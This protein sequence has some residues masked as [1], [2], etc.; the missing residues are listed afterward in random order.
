MVFALLS[1]ISNGL[2]YV[3]ASLKSILHRVHCIH[4]VHLML[5][6]LSSSTLFVALTLVV[7]VVSKSYLC[8]LTVIVHGPLGRLLLSVTIPY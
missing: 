6:W 3:V 4:L 7:S 8:K 1:I 5:Y 2:S